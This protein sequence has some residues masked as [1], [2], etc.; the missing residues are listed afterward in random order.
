MVSG[1]SYDRRIQDREFEQLFEEHAQSLFRF[2]LYRTGDRGLSED[3]TADAFERALR[4]RAGFDHRRSSAK[5][6]LYAIALNCL[7]DHARRLAAES[8]AIQRL[9]DAPALAD[10]SVLEGVGLR[11]ELHRALRLLS[12]EE[13]EAIA[14]RFGADLTLPEIARVTGLRLTTVEGRV[15]GGLRRLRDALG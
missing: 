10:D 8:R 6:W 4:S 2:L 7:R 5:T 9:P 1:S 11:D 13:R 3:L 15:Y 14:L 12:E